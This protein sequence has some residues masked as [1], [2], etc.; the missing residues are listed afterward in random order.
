MQHQMSPY[1][2]TLTPE[3]LAHI[4]DVRDQFLAAALSTERVDRTAAEAA[5]RAACTAAGLSVPEANIWADSPAGGITAAQPLP[6]LSI[7]QALQGP[8]MGGL[9]SSLMARMAA[10]IGARPSVRLCTQVGE[11]L[12]D[13]L[14]APLWGQIGRP[15]RD[16][17]NEEFGDQHEIFQHPW[18]DTYWL[19]T[20]TAALSIAGL[21]D[22]RLTALAEATRTL[23]WWCYDGRRLVLTDRPTAIRLDNQGRLHC[24]T[25]PALIYA[26]GYSLYSWHGLRV[27]AD[28][29][30]G[31]G[32][33][34]ARILREPNAEVRRA[35]IE[36]MGWDQFIPAVGLIQVGRSRRDP[37]NP[38]HEI[39]LWDVPEEIYGGGAVRIL[40]CTNGS[41]DRDG[42]RRQFGLTV[43]ARFRTPLGAAAWT[44]G[45]TT[46]EY[47]A[48]TRRT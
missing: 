28:L 26:D 11:Q 20:Y 16:R 5:A 32:W 4:A 15:L 9:R 18:Q 14:G 41:P 35:A 2:G 42:T 1:R 44:Y 34:V 12:Q 48:L 22:A 24:E 17:L 27:P 29:V 47:A 25:G 33:D 40:L 37:G 8:L 7:R 46:G 3:H 43:P 31:P 6:S 13:Q 45:C 39:S 36:R 21:D 23:G 10:Q 38:G 19:A 30:E